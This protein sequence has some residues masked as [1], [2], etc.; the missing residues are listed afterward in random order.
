MTNYSILVVEDHLMFGNTLVHLLNEQTPYNVIG[1]LRSGEEALK[2]LS[3]TDVD[4]V[5]IDVSLPH[6]NGI[7]LVMNIKEKFPQVRCLILSGHMTPAYVKQALDAG[8]RGYI[9]KDDVA[10]VVQGVETV[11]RGKIFLS[12]ALRDVVR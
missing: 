11:M 2:F 5:L 1:P 8:A 3:H 10:G 12:A 7:E 9:L 6:M 4:L